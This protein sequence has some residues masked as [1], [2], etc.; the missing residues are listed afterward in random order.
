MSEDNNIEK[1]VDPTRSAVLSELGGTGLRNQS[2]YIDE[3]ITRDLQWPRCIDVYKRMET[4]SLIA[5]ALFAI[6]QFMRR[7]DWHVEE[8]SGEDAPADKSQQAMF[9]EQCLDDLDRPWADFIT[10]ALSFLTYGFSVHEIVYKVRMGPK[11]KNPRL[12]SKY[13]DGKYGWRKFPIRSQDTIDKWD[14]DRH[15]ELEGVHQKDYMNGFDAYIPFSKML[16]FR[17]TTYKDNPMGKSILRDAYY[18]YYFKR[19]I[20][21]YEA[22][23]IE[24]DLAG[25][26]VISIPLEY[27]TPDATKEQKATLAQFQRMGANIKRNEQAYIMMPSDVD[28]SG[29]KLFDIKPFSSTGQSRVDANTVINRHAHHMMHSMLTD[30]IL[31]GSQSVGSYALSSSKVM[32]FVTAIESYLDTIAYQFNHKAIPMLWEMNGWD[33]AKC[34]TI[35]HNGVESVDL[36]ALGTFLKNAGGSG[37]LTPDDDTEDAVRDI[38]NLPKRRPESEETSRASE[39]RRQQQSQ[40]ENNVGAEQESSNEGEE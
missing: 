12:K 14:I 37:F 33:S 15:G 7:S 10:D 34:P 3:E 17:T 38:A 24:R 9:L 5:G 39:L 31:M 18:A 16:L 25:I 27:M 22:I 23:G 20:E 40:P 30:F 6:R 36:E 29:N 32:A 21:A 2:G 11:Q 4:D 19:N 1:A 13:S 35:A 26:P 28:E 8:Y